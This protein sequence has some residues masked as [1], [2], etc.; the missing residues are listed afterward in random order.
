M[1]KLK[2]DNEQLTMIVDGLKSG[3]EHMKQEK[4]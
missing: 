1:S 2:L 4:D 3:L